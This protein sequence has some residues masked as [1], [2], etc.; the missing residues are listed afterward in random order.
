M[1][2]D[3]KI[4][5]KILAN[6]IQQ[7][8]I[9]IIYYDQMEFIPGVQEWFNKNKSINITLHINKMKDKS[10]SHLE[11]HRKNISQHPFITKTFNILERKGI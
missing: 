8:I 2:I 6:Q 4:Y 10:Y 3:A 11:R 5:N 7:R 1:N 9:R